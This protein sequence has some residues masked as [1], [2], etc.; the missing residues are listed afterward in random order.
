MFFKELLVK[1]LLNIHTY[2][3]HILFFV[4]LERYRKKDIGE[5]N[6]ITSPYLRL[7]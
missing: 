1:E 3:L 2:P 7:S 5:I 6:F 4:F